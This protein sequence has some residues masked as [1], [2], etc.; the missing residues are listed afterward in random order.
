M[1]LYFWYDT[2]SDDNTKMKELRSLAFLLL[3][4][5]AAALALRALDKQPASVYH[6]RRVALAGQLHGG[7]AVLFALPEP[8]LDFMPYRQGFDFPHHRVE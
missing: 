1:R 4:V 3:A 5:S 6:A 8:E 7:V 2:P